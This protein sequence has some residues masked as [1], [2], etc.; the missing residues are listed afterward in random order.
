[1]IEVVLVSSFLWVM[2]GIE[3]ALITFCTVS[4][5]AWFTIQVTEWRMAFRRQMNEADEQAATKAVDSLLNFE[6]VKYFN[7]EENEAKRYD[8][9]LRRYEDAAVLSRTSLAG[10]EY[11]ARVLLLSDWF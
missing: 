8:I 1:M 5:Y 6:T 3:Y 4:L 9:S 11:W 2:F 7:A 10:R